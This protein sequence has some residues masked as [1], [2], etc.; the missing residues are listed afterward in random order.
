[1]SKTLNKLPEEKIKKDL[2]RSLKGVDKFYREAVSNPHD[3]MLNDKVSYS[4]MRAA[5][6]LYQQGSDDYTK[7]FKIFC[8]VSANK[9]EALDIPRSD[10]ET[11]NPWGFIYTLITAICY[12]EDQE[13]KRLLSIKE[14]I[15]CSPK[16]EPPEYPLNTARHLKTVFSG[17]KTDDYC[18]KEIKTQEN[19]LNHEEAM[20]LKS[21]NDG[22]S[23]ITNTDHKAW[24]GSIDACLEK[25]IEEVEQGDLKLKVEA[26]I[27]LPA[28]VLHKIGNAI[29]FN[30]DNKSKYLPVGAG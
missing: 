21:L 14:E 15:Y 24:A 13:I 6:M 2:A 27:C 25:H 16:T 29:D 22:L 18:A 19:K 1:M 28:L 12:G 5:L 17:N 10:S 8:E 9:Y 7:Y 3:Y 11:R 30:Y 20:Y 4:S 23:A 26:F